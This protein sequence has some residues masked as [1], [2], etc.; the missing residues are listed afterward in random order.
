MAKS[1]QLG[2]HV[3]LPLAMEGGDF[4]YYFIYFN[5][6]FIDF[7]YLWDLFAYIIKSVSSNILANVVYGMGDSASHKGRKHFIRS[8]TSFKV[9]HT[10]F[11]K[12]I[13]QSG[14]KVRSVH[15]LVSKQFV[16]TLVTTSSKRKSSCLI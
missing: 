12:H 8:T 3:W 9:I 2:L 13:M 16:S 11:K 15:L 6:F 7:I 1:A 10:I 5:H 4:N 14:L